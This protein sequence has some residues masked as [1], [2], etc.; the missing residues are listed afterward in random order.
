MSRE[1]FMIMKSY[2]ETLLETLVGPSESLGIF[3]L[4]VPYISGRFEVA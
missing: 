1:R 2:K 3:H 4:A